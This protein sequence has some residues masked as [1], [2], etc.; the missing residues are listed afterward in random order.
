MN[1]SNELDEEKEKLFL[2]TFNNKSKNLLKTYSDSENEN[3]ES[4]VE[5]LDINNALDKQK[6]INF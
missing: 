5:S 4:D 3:Q 6:N 2:K 1:L